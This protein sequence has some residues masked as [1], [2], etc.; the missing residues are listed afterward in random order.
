MNSLVV[1]FGEVGA[2]VAKVVNVIDA[3]YVVDPAVDQQTIPAD[4]EVMH[5]CFPPSDSFAF[6][7]QS[8]YAQFN[9]KHV[10]IW[11][12]TP[13]GTTQAL[14][15]HA[16]HSPIEGVH[17]YLAESIFKMV[18]F[19][20]ADD[21]VEGAYFAAYFARMDM[22]TQVLSSSKFTEFLK[23]RSTSKYGINIVWAGYEKSV[24]DSL[25]MDFKEVDAYDES[26]NS[27]YMAMGMPQ[28][29][30]YLLKPPAGPIGGHC[31]VQNAKILDKQFPSALL[32]MIVDFE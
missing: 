17:P 21:P 25:G 13:I 12:S 1:G 28:Y 7:V 26:Y 9:P 32:R 2:S 4:I 23:L 29:Q 20:G 10:L 18:R 15:I 11:S 8:Y 6:Q 16:V 19:L 31:V 30:R 27:L 14:G 3:V 5:I 22:A 24:A